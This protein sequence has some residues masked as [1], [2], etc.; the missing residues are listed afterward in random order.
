MIRTIVLASA[1]LLA[2]CATAPLPD[3]MA[4]HDYRPYAERSGA[5]CGD[6]Q[7]AAFRASR[8]KKSGDP[9]DDELA[10]R[11]WDISTPEPSKAQGDDRVLT[12]H[13]VYEIESDPDTIGRA[14][15]KICMGGQP[16]R[17]KPH[18]P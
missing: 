18:A 14:V 17:V 4:P 10:R 2:A 3:Y 15:Y 11:N 13:D 16:W 9:L 7:T 12:A 1:V 5:Y 8:H 6:M